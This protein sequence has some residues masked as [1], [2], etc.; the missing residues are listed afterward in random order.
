MRAPRSRRLLA[1]TASALALG[2]LPAC[3]GDGP[4]R[5]APSPSGDRAGGRHLALHGAVNVR[6]LGGYRTGE[7]ERVR[8]GRV[9]RADSLNRLTEAD[10]RKLSRLDLRT[11]VDLR[12]PSEV[13]H[14]GRD[15]LPDGLTVTARPVDDLGLYARTRE[16]IGAKDP[17]RQR[18]LLGDGKARKLMRAVYRNFVTDAA[19]RRQFA[20]VVRDVAEG[21][22]SPLLF[23]CTSGKDRTGWLGYVLLRA[24]GVP[25]A[26]AE[27]DYLASNTYRAGADRRTREG[28]RKS[29]MMKQPELLDGL[30]EV[31]RAYL[32]AALAQAEEDYGGF[33]GY[34]TEG[35]GLDAR[36]LERLRGRLLR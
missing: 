34:L 14:D 35:L 1:A 20:R 26:T 15:R 6:D 19:G 11:V 7:G 13:R 32:D 3:S 24:V 4:P 9:F 28:L 31:R 16:A 18:Q 2:L 36:T 33:R 10:T 22:T 27:K 17:E 8:T 30:L 23:H 25:A 21:G 29:G 5:E 12:T